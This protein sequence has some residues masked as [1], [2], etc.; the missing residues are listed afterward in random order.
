MYSYGQEASGVYTPGTQFNMDTNKL[1]ELGFNQDDIQLMQYVSSMR[2][3]VTT[4]DL[5]KNGIEPERAKRVKYMFDIASGRVSIES[6]D[7]LS[8][9]FRK[10]F[11]Q[12]K[13]IGIQDLA[14]SKVNKVPRWAVVAGIKDE[15]YQCLNSANMTPDKK[16][17]TVEKVGAR[18]TCKTKV[19]PV[20][21][22][23]YP[24][25]IDGVLEILGIEKNTGL[26]VIAFDK[27]H[28]RLCNR[29]VIVAS[30]RIPETHLGMVKIVC[31]EGT[32]LY[33]YAKNIGTREN[34]SYSGGNARVYDYGIRPNEILPRV[35][36]VAENV[37]KAMCG[38]YA[39]C[40][41]PNEAFNLL[42][43]VEKDVEIEE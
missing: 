10:L 5:I 4:A 26:T 42:A 43:T 36:A 24:K 22:Y 35:K 1:R 39:T 25:K 19:R 3:N 29:Y 33:V 7:D 21:P 40:I 17:Y 18:V 9:H 23:K 27:K 13:R 28:C 32:K 37:Y 16:L 15:V 2:G 31:V 6:E 41:Q 12:H 8:K 38:V 14:I 20:I 30:L 34:V 11:G